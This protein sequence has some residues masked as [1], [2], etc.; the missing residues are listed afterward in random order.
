M[1]YVVS[2]MIA[3][4]KKAWKISLVPRSF[5]QQL[6]YWWQSVFMIIYYM[7]FWTHSTKHSIMLAIFLRTSPTKIP[8]HF[9]DWKKLRNIGIFKKRDKEQITWN[10]Q[11]TRTCH[12]KAK[13]YKRE[14]L[15]GTLTYRPDYLLYL[16]TNMSEWALELC[17]R[18]KGGVLFILQ[19]T[20]SKR[21]FLTL[22]SSLPLSHHNFSSKY[23]YVKWALLFRLLR[24]S[25]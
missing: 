4:N 23:S 15:L 9:L 16:S 7:L 8:I 5:M 3:Y 6:C 1:F 22:T 2:I 10:L 25:L 13:N 12:F 19:F 24:F 14:E 21:G 11:W 18:P 17:I 20:K